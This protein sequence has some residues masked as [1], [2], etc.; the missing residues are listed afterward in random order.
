MIEMSLAEAAAAVEGEWTGAAVRFTAVATDSRQL[1]PG[2][3]FVAL[4]GARFDGHAFVAEAAR[5]GAVAAL[6]SEPVADLPC[7]R[8]AD[9]RLALGRLAAAWRDRFPR[10]VIGLTGSNGKTTV[11]QM[12]A[13]ILATRGPVLATQGN[14]NNDIGVPLTLLR[15]GDEAHAVI[16]M[17]ANH[18]GEIAWLTGLVRPEV[19]LINNA[20]PAHLE[21]FGSL[22]GVARAK[23]EIYRGL[24]PRGLGIVNAD[25]GYA[26]FWRGL[27]GERP[28]LSFGLDRPADVQGVVL[29]A[30]RNRLR[31][32]AGGEAVEF[33]LPLP[34]R[35][36]ARNALAAA[37]AALAVGLDLDAV[38]AGLATLPAVSGRL[39]ALP[40]RHGGVVIHDAYN[41]NPASLAAALQTLSR[42]P[43][44]KWLVLGDMGELGPEAPALHAE[45]GRQARAAGFAHCYAVGEHSREAV[46]AFGA[47]AWH[48]PDLDALL[49]AVTGALAGAPDPPL[50]LI[51]GSRSQRLERAV[52]ALVAGEMR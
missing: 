44:S 5:R 27:I 7:I 35:H 1:A 34:G 51:K 8:V 24:G 30:D 26:E 42:R 40:G 21:G 36:N 11:K 52:Q 2:A 41:A 6:V 12:I 10:P 37:A 13:A 47:G 3:L 23:G 32:R 50:L 19:A 9:T 4:R 31:I 38:S 45:A 17:G 28:C 20:G 33:E 29:D 18:P 39:Q 46:A 43:G 22:D 14:L 16:E 49:A 48:F 25:D 15:L